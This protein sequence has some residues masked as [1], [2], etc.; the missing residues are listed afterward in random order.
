M[1]STISS[2]NWVVFKGVLKRLKWFSILYGIALFLELP[3]LLWM[4]FDRQKSVQGALWVANKSFQPQMIFHP[5]AHLTNLA[6]AVIFGLI[7]FYYLHQERANTFFHSLPIK[8]SALYVQ[9][10]LAGLT[11]TWLPLLI[12]GLLI[13]GV[14]SVF[15]VSKGQWYN[16]QVYGPGMDMANN[17]STTLPL[18]QIMGYWIFLNLVMTGLF[19]IFTVF[20]GML[21]GNVLL[22]GALTVIG[23][24]LPLGFYLLVKYSL[25]KLLYGFPRNVNDQGIEWFSPLV[26]YFSVIGS[27]STSDQLGWYIAYLVVALVLVVAGIYLYGKRHAEAAGETLASEWMRWLF[28]Y[29]VTVCAALTA[30]LYFGSLNENSN[31]VLY[32]GYLI[33]AVL[34]YSVSDMIAYKSF[35]FYKRWKGLLIFGAIFVVLLGAIKLD[36]FGYQRYIPEASEIKAVY[37]TN[38]FGDGYARSSSEPLTKGLTST[39]NIERVRQLQQVIVENEDKNRALERV[40]NQQSNSP[41]SLVKAPRVRFMPMDITYVLK[42][43]SKV[44]RVYNVDVFQYRKELSSIFNTEEAKLSMYGGFFQLNSKKIDQINVNNFH[45]G[46]SV[47]IYKRTEIKEAMDALSKDV[48]NVTFE[49][50]IEGKVPVKTGVEF[51]VKV[52]PGQSYSPYNLNCYIGFKNFDAFLAGH[53]YAKELFLNP[54]EVKKISIKQAGTNKKTEVFDKQKIEYLLNSCNLSDEQAYLGKLQQMDNQGM[55]YFGEVVRENGTS[56]FVVFDST[57]VIQEELEKLIK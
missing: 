7:V 57:L 2:K 45:L 44:Q 47:R 50:A 10:L 13:Y 43:G 54:D 21:T 6:I 40:N 46:K 18:W 51:F 33:G 32:F 5:I 49:A 28:K 19:F 31:G 1:T 55:Q 26:S 41:A 25:W 20:I 27:R 4:D 42:D 53:G 22:Q 34:G 37:L 56:L 16:P 12:N 48:R 23:L 17:A 39:K 15:G 24:F 3:V 29:G 14:F 8:R 35:H 30:G 9:N 52:K 11:L 36:V 38:L